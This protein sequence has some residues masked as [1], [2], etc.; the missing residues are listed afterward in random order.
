[1]DT[2]NLKALALKC[3]SKKKLYGVLLTDC[4]VYLYAFSLRTHNT[5]KEW[6]EKQ[7]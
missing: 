1:M 7:N 6:W 2:I 4:D 5:L 3:R